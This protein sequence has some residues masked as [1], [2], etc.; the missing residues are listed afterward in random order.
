MTVN[1]ALWFGES[2]ILRAIAEKLKRRSK[3]RSRQAAPQTSEYVIMRVARGG[4]SE[5][6]I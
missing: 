5:A 6:V 3:D 4:A 2:T 1:F